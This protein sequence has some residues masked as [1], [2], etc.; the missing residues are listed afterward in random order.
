LSLFHKLWFLNPYIFATQ[1]CKSLIFQYMNSFRSDNLSFKYQWFTS[2]IR[3]FVFV[4]KTLFLS[5]Y[6]K[7]I[8]RD[9][10]KNYSIITFQ[11]WALSNVKPV[12]Q[13]FH[14]KKFKH[15]INEKDRRQ[16]SFRCLFHITVFT[17]LS[18]KTSMDSV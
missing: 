12:L 4:A 2:I 6:F 14:S 3:K 7:Y 10:N 15:F 1:S 9:I 8:E 13:R 5:K 11:N 17:I 18:S 16:K